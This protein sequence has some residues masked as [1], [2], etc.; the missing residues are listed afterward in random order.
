[1][2]DTQNWLSRKYLNAYFCKKVNL[3]TCAEL[4][5][6]NRKFGIQTN[7]PANGS[8]GHWWDTRA[9]KRTNFDNRAQ[10]A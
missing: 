6:S 10:K 2:N 7:C 5:N 1:M 3:R 8:M 4:F 9:Q